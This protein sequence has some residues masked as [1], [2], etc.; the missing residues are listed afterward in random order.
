MIRKITNQARDYAWGSKTLIADFF[1]L[2]A[3][4]G[5]M[6][7][8]WYGTHPG[9]LTFIADAPSTTVLDALGGKPL[10][11]LLKILAAGEPL[12]IQAHPNSAQAQ[13]GFARENAAGLPLDAANRNYKDDRHK[14]EM[15]VALVDGFEAL[16][17][18]RDVVEATELFKSFGPALA[19]FAELLEQPNGLRLA[20][21]RAFELKGS[22]G[23]I[24]AEL[25]RQSTLAA[26]LEALYPGDPGIIV[27]LLMNHVSLRAGEGLYLPAGNIH[28]YL[29][30]LGVEIMAASDNVL[31][32]GL[33][34]K[35][36]DVAELQSVVDF[37]SLDVEY[38]EPTKVLNGL[39][40]YEAD[41]PDFALYRVDLTGS[42]VL[43]DLEI[44]GDSILLCTHGEI[45]VS[46]SLEE[47]VVLKRGEAALVTADARFVSLAGSGT[48]FLAC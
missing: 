42:T 9:S 44:S 6:A 3:T 33:T 4:G 11:F 40:R 36:V 19:E 22:L 12:S 26:R 16:C 43:A 37:S 30:G 10:S 23:D 31:R 41:C 35:H 17:G 38:L 27:A 32:G 20:F 24:T 46:D 29:E 47:R 18:F 14:P 21:N 8:I 13:A 2:P 1:G 25:A 45:A 34:P 5:P 28:A 15:I 48:A 7:E 39:S